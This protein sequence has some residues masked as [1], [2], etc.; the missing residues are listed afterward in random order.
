MLLLG[1]ET[2]ENAR[3]V[4][5]RI[6]NAFNTTRHE[7]DGNEVELFISIGLATFDAEADFSGSELIEAADEALKYAKQHGKA[8]VVEYSSIA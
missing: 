5:D 1:G 3:I 2:A 7:V 6:L 4:C 8:Q